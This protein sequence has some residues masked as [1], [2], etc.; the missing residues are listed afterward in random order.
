M[1][2]LE[3]E[4]T[5]LST[6][7]LDFASKLVHPFDYCQELSTLFS[8]MFKHEPYFDRSKAFESFALWCTLDPRHLKIC[9]TS[10]PEFA[11]FVAR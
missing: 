1:T 10:N 7:K 2:A 4:P 9:G 6:T 5:T 3:R 8:F 11:R